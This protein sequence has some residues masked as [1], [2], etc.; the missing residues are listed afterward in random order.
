MLLRTHRNGVVYLKFIEVQRSL[1]ELQ[2]YAGLRTQQR[3]AS[4]QRNTCCVHQ[5]IVLLGAICNVCSLPLFI[6]LHTLTYSPRTSHLAPLTSHLSPLTS[7]VFYPFTPSHSQSL[8]RGLVVLPLTI[9]YYSQAI[10]NKSRANKNN[11][12]NQKKTINNKNKNN[13][14]N[15]TNNH[16]NFKNT[17][18]NNDN[19]KNNLLQNNNIQ[20][21]FTGKTKDNANTHKKSNNIKSNI[22]SNNFKNKDPN[23]KHKQIKSSTNIN[24]KDTN[25]NRETNRVAELMNTTNKNENSQLDDND[26]QERSKEID[27][28]AIEELTPYANWFF[29]HKCELEKVCSKMEQIPRNSLPQVREDERR[30]RDRRGG[31][32]ERRIRG[33]RDKR[34][35]I[36]PFF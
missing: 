18:K 20:P 5:S 2:S 29:A 6:P 13:F 23:V 26:Q 15:T 12:R 4:H 31:E 35:I 34:G 10:N 30:E 11:E 19:N 25:Q 28:K 17:T 16:K 24:T 8:G 3:A 21:N 22:T 36:F 1:V 27:G 9:R 32:K 14:T 33:R 7:P